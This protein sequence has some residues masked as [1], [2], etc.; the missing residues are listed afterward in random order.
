MEKRKEIMRII[1]LAVSL[2]T[3]FAILSW[4]ILFFGF[5]TINIIEMEFSSLVLFS[6]VEVVLIVFMVLLWYVHRKL[7]G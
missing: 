6:F 5:S 7:F 3:A 4:P 2:F 1:F